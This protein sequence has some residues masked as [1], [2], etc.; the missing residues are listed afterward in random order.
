MTQRL[1][2]ALHHTCRG[3]STC[4]LWVRGNVKA[5][6]ESA[7]SLCRQEGEKTLKQVHA[8]LDAR[9]HLIRSSHT[10]QESESHTQTRT[11]TPKINSLNT[12]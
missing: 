6:G 10:V 9:Q 12:Q 1:S 3:R 2:T 11:K 5:E 8:G 4:A 7:A